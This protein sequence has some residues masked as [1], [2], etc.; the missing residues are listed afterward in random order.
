MELKVLQDNGHS[1]GFLFAFLG[2]MKKI[3]SIKDYQAVQTTLE[4]I[5]NGFAKEDS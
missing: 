1:I 4:Q 2:R 3:Y 5:F